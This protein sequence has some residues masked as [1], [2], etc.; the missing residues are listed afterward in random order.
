MDLGFDGEKYAH[1]ST[2]QKEWGLKVI[3]ELELTGRESI[4]DL[5][6]GD[7]ALTFQLASLV[8]EGYAVGIDSS[9]SMI[10][11]AKQHSRPNLDFKLQSMEEIE[12]ENAFDLVFSNAAL[13]WVKNHEILLARVFRALKDG[14]ICRFNF[15]GEGNCPTFNRAVQEVMAQARYADF[16]RGFEWPWFM[17][18][19]DEYRLFLLRFPFRKVQVWG[20]NADRFFPDAEALIRWI[21]QPSLVPFLPSVPE[22]EKAYFRAEVVHRMLRATL[23]ENGK[24]FE[25]FRRINV[26]ARK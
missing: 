13:H 20:E 25:Q 22:G 14:G 17:P 15:P 3:A 2:H 24:Y 10:A 19:V 23:R 9:P 11:T 7:G 16:F 26:L 6:C 4:L 5:G 18:D 1:A 21:D 12:Y 8:P